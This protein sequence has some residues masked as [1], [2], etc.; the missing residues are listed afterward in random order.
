MTRNGVEPI[1]ELCDAI[2]KIK[3]DF[4][5]ITRPPLRSEKSTHREQMSSKGSPQKGTPPS[6]KHV[7]AVVD[8]KSIL[9]QK[10][11]TRPPNKTPYIPLGGSSENS[12]SNP[13]D[14]EIHTKKVVLEKENKEQESEESKMSQP[15]TSEEMKLLESS[16]ESGTEKEVADPETVQ[17]EQT[18]QLST[19]NGEK[20]SSSST[21]ESDKL[22]ESDEEPAK[23]A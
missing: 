4:E 18:S 10:L 22:L 1:N 19:S 11:V 5:S 7:L 17:D 13:N 9:T 2:E 14:V 23:S 15:S 8:I 21:R 20:S 12:P 16:N 3:V 6:S